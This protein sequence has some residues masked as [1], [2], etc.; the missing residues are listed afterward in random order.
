MSKKS[1]KKISRRDALK[2]GGIAFAA[3]LASCNR[4]RGD[5]N[6]VVPPTVAP[7][8]AGQTPA[9]GPPPEGPADLVL[10]GGKVYTVDSVNSIKE[11]VAIKDGLIQAASSDKDMNA[12]TGPNTQVVGSKRPCRYAGSH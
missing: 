7:P 1:S 8:A 11:A 5:V 12:F 9:V 10:K 4:Q 3:A 6:T 2:I